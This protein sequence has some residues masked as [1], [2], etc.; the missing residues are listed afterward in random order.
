MLVWTH[1]YKHWRIK[2]GHSSLL[3]RL[4]TTLAKGIIHFM[5]SNIFEQ[6]GSLKLFTLT[7]LFRLRK[8][9]EK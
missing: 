2:P 3:N 8:H 4:V 9:A 1:V 5:Q 6:K 7:S